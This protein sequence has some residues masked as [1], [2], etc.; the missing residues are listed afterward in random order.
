MLCIDKKSIEKV[1]V[2][3][4][5]V[6][7]EGLIN[8]HT[9]HFNN[10]KEAYKENY[11]PLDF[12][13]SVRSMYSNLVLEI[14]M[15]D[16]CLYYTNLTDIQKFEHKGYDL[17]MFVSSLGVMSSFD[18]NDDF[19]RCMLEHSQFC[20]IGLYNPDP[21]FINP[22]VYSHIILSDEGAEKIKEHLK[23]GRKFVPIKDMNVKGNLIA[24]TDTL[25]EVKPK[26]ENDNE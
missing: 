19:K 3:Q 1:N 5:K 7:L 21:E 20:P 16:K 15:E 4:N 14:S 18:V 17:V 12:S 24:M 23:D 25:I 8:N 2:I 26:E 10:V 11:V 6:D 9:K 22:I 13:V